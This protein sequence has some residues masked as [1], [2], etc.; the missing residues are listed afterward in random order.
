[1]RFRP[2]FSPGGV[3]RLVRVLAPTGRHR[4]GHARSLGLHSSRDNPTNLVVSSFFFG[5]GRSLTS[6][7]APGPPRERQQ[8]KPYSAVP[9]CRTN[10][11]PVGVPWLHVLGRV[12]CRTGC[13]RSA[14]RGGGGG[15][16]G[17]LLVCCVSCRGLARASH[18]HSALSASNTLEICLPSSLL[19]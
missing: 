16:G 6:G 17:H 5:V 4:V 11:S 19:L 14:E 7:G 1:M 15:E 18:Y 8:R 12:T 13:W 9:P 2:S 3:L 10:D